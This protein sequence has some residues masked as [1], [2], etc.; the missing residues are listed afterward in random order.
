[1][2]PVQAGTSSILS[3]PKPTLVSSVSTTDT[4]RP[5]LAQFLSPD[6]TVRYG[7]ERNR[8]IDTNRPVAV[9]SRTTDEK[10]SAVRAPYMPTPI[11]NSNTKQSQQ[12]YPS[13]NKPSIHSPS[14][15]APILYRHY[16][17]IQPDQKSQ[18]EIPMF[19]E[20]TFRMKSLDLNVV[21]ERHIN[22]H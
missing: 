2:N 18:R 16:F 19:I 20:T 1:M 14:T 10:N 15:T 17:R 21:R 12:S 7:D 5:P 11:S 8:F 3:V 6:R 4:N 9:N 13:I 22:H